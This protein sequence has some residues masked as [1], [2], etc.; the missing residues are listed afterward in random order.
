MIEL[1]ANTA[2]MLYLCLTLAVIMSLWLNHHYHSRRKKIVTA[3]HE[4][5]VCEYC[6]CAYL[7]D[8]FK[9]VTQCPQCKLFNKNNKY[10]TIE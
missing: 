1:T 3:E 8:D 6:H 5:H 7:E 4:L 2:V 10:K 9:D